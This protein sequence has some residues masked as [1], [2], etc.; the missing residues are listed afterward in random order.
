ML[1][2]R[3]SGIPYCNAWVR[4]EDCPYRLPDGFLPRS[5]C[6]PACRRVA[7]ALET[8]DASRGWCEDLAATPGLSILLH[9]PFLFLLI[10]F[11][12]TFHPTI[13]GR[14]TLDTVGVSTCRYIREKNQREWIRR[15]R[16]RLWHIQ[17][18]YYCLHSS[19]H[20]FF[21]W[22]VLTLN[23]SPQTK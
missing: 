5:L 22:I 19:C 11:F 14:F 18:S 8:D 15:V 3:S 1:W 4:T 7:C 17:G 10:F 9:R 16:P 21:R 2:V 12:F 6:C 13:P 20:A 23:D